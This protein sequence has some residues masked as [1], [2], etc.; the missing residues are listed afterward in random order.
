MNS[1]NLNHKLTGSGALLNEKG[2]DGAGG[3]VI[4]TSATKSASDN[5]GDG[6]KN[7]PYNLFETA[8]ANASDGDTIYILAPKGFVNAS[9]NSPLI[10]NS[11]SFNILV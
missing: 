6:T 11:S 1:K 2:A 9:D 5:S 3:K 10:I 7:N 4:Y 8:L